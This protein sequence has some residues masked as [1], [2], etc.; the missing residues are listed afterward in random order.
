MSIEIT[1]A[2]MH[3]LGIHNGTITVESENG[4][5]NEIVIRIPFGDGYKAKERAESVYNLLMEVD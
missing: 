2:R 4:W 1:E 5:Y 3:A